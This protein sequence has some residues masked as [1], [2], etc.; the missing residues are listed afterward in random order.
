MVI[1]AVKGAWEHEGCKKNVKAVNDVH[2]GGDDEILVVVGAVSSSTP[3]A[4]GS[5]RSC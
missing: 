2:D 5:L 1:A 3:V 4:C